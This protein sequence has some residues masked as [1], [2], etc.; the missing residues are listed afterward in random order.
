MSA[1][2]TLPSKSGS[3]QTGSYSG[4]LS[5]GASSRAAAPAGSTVRDG[6]FEF[7]VLNIT[8]TS[9]VDDPDGNPYVQPVKP[10]GV[11]YVVTMSVRNIGD[12][13]QTYFGQNQKLIDSSGRQYG[14]HFQADMRFGPNNLTADINPGL[15]I[16]VRD[17]FDVPPGTSA[18]KLELHDS[19][20]SGGA[21]I[22][23]S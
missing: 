11:F 20:F 17:A 13:P 19:A 16:Q 9:Q 3:Q 2:C 10:Q 23:L 4:G 18:S 8:Q 1:G 14:S 22:L 15:S 7:Q 5:S 6:K 12:K 21:T